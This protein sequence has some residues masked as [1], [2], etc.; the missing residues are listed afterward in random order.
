[1]LLAVN[2]RE[3]EEEREHGSFGDI[4]QLCPQVW[5]RMETEANLKKNFFLY[6][7][8]SKIVFLGEKR[9]GL[10]NMWPWD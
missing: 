5:N 3:T 10:P 2:W 9:L 7:L 8:L 4:K 1:M 6:F